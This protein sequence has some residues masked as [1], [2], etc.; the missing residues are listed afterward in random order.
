MGPHCDYETALERLA[1][2]V[3][4]ARRANDPVSLGFAL[5]NFGT[6]A[7]AA[8]QLESAAAALEEALQ[9]VEA[10]P[11]DAPRLADKRFVLQ[12]LGT[13]DVLAGR[14]RDARQRMD[15]AIRIAIELVEPEGLAGGLLGLARL[16][17]LEDQPER[18]ARLLG[19][20]DAVL[21]DAGIELERFDADER[22]RTVEMTKRRLGSERYQQLYGQGRTL[23]VH[24][25]GTVALGGDY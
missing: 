8:G 10:A 9:L 20:A 2:S 25:A 15:D 5:S 7:T 22:A 4:I 13:V 23:S 19:A 1:A 3:E 11:A 18:S 14:L 16:A 21:A 24:E 17:T 12:S 6:T